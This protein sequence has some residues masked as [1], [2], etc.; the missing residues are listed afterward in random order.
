M[1]LIAGC[2]NPQSGSGVVQ[3]QIKVDQ[4]IQTLFFSQGLTVFDAIE[5]SGIELGSG[6]KISPPGY[7]VLEDDIEIEI[8]R[9]EERLEVLSTVLPFERQIIKNES[10]P[11][12]ERRLLQPGENGE[13]EITYRVTEENGVESTRVVIKRIVIKE[14][15]PEIMMI[16]S[17]QSY[18]P[19]TFPGKMAYVSAQNAWLIEGET[20]NR[21][22][23][24]STGDLDG[25]I[26]ELSPDGQW[27]M[28]TRQLA[29]PEEGI[30]SLWLLDLDDPQGEMIDLQVKNI[31]HF[32]DWSPQSPNEFS[33]Y[34]IAYSTVESR[35]SAPGWQ[36]N[37]DLH[38]LGITDEG[39]VFKREI[40]LEANP[41]GQYGWWGTAFSWSP[42]ADVIAYSRADSIGLVNVDSGLIEELV[43]IVPYQ[44]QGDWAWLPPIAWGS[45]SQIL[46][47]VS[48]G[49]PTG[50][51]KPEA[52]EVF[53]L[54]ALIIKQGTMGPL[55]RQ[56]GM[57]TYLAPSP[58]YDLVSSEEAYSLAFLQAFDPLNSEASHY[59][60]MV[61]DRD[62][63]NLQSIF[64]AEGEMGLEP[65]EI[66]WAYDGSRIGTLYQ[67]D[68]W[69]IDLASGQ[70]HCI[71]ADH[72]TSAFDWSQ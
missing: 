33:Q 70:A 16:G 28:F 63:S 7:T 51:E 1:L 67:N 59:Q 40:I 5:A 39:F 11:L 27:L 10:I 48:H 22:P 17:Q 49:K 13:E 26:L 38:I 34:T 18:T 53:D 12:D 55:I 2:T 35:P 47:Y 57:F 69:V 71:T 32:A 66:I 3:V 30:N 45:N 20:G 19:L 52:S 64:P 24:V 72:Q 61:M 41:G 36:A 4:G 46:Y 58:Q 15:V 65:A 60:L 54:M 29:D 31:I 6:D 14:P 43:E 25:R 50:L 68:L 62:G 56:S 21:L 37:N 23:I 44:T 42:D 9:V 8:T